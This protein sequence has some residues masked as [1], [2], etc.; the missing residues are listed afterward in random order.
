[1]DRREFLKI[2]GSAALALAARRL[3]ARHILE[4]DVLINVPVAKHRSTAGLTIGMKNLMGATGD[5]RGRWHWKLAESICDFNHGHRLGELSG[6]R[7]R[8]D[9]LG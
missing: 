7:R 6:Y 9:S 5:N 2:A 8:E 1:M 4:A 3:L